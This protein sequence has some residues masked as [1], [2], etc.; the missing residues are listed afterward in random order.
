MKRDALPQPAGIASIRQVLPADRHDKKP[1][2]GVALVTALCVVYGLLFAAALLVDSGWLKAALGVALGLTTG[3]LFVVGHDASHGSLMHSA[4]VN[5]WLARICFLPSAH[6]NEAWD[7]EH[8]RQHHSW[9]NLSTKDPGY[10]PLSLEAYSALSPIGKAWHRLGYV[11][12]FIATSYLS[13]WWRSQIR[14]FKPRLSMVRS[15]RVFRWEVAGIAAFFMLQSWLVWRAGAWSAQGIGWGAAEWL[16]C[17]ALPFYVWNTTM[18]FVTI[19]H[20]THPNVR[21][22]D[23]ESE[24]SVFAGQV[25]GTVH[26]TW[27]LWFDLAF[28]NIFQHTAHHT[29]KHVPLYKLRES[30]QALSNAF[31]DAITEQSG[32]LSNLLKVLKTCRIYDYRGHRWMGWDGA[33]SYEP[34]RRIQI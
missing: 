27:P 33:V 34:T 31:P 14:I 8:N 1:W 12:P 6:P 9:T 22:Y 28:H 15:L 4:G 25:E 19:Q 13:I 3:V 20:H 2:V 7:S 32:S 23:N 29:D 24:W 16:L 18:A 5:R 26:V 17:I 21:W 11:L 10:P 30:Q